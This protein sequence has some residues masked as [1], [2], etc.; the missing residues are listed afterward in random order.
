EGDLAS[1]NF[2]EQALTM[3][4]YRAVGPR[5]A[6]FDILN[7]L[8]NQIR[9]AQK[10]NEALGRGKKFQIMQEMLAIMGCS[11]EDMQGVLKSLGFQSETIKA[12]DLP[13]APET[14]P[15]TPT[16]PKPESDTIA[17]TASA[18]IEK[19]A[20]T[21]IETGATPE[22]TLSSESAAT[23]APVETQIAEASPAKQAAPAPK[24]RQK[25][26]NIYN[27]RV[28]QED[29]TTIDA[30]N[31]EFWFMPR[32]K[33]HANNRNKNARQGEGSRGKFKGKRKNTKSD[34]SYKAKPKP[35][36]NI[37]NSPFA[38]LAALKTDKKD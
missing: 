32:K 29:G 1:A 24:N 27:H 25:D 11:Y 8:G 9:Q 17:E 10:Q 31:T 35:T 37:E 4:G 36:R 20:D 21:P 7:R 16:A 5:I 26:L 3:A 14:V 15:E 22:P 19:K 18:P 34:Q 2:S 6:R 38:A 30:I 33:P 13:P 23:P 28:E 12:E